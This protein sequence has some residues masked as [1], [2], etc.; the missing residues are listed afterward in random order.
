MFFPVT[1]LVGLLVEPYNLAVV[2]L[3]GALILW[4]LK[5]GRR[6]RRALVI[7]AASLV[8]VFGS[9]PVANLLLYP[10]ETAHARPASLPRSPGAIIVLGGFTDDPRDNPNFY[11]LTEAADR[12]V[13]GVRLAHSFPGARLVISGG[14]SAVIYRFYKEGAVLGSL[15]LDMGLPAR[16]VLVDSESRNTHEN[17]LH[18]KRLLATVKGP[19]VLITSAAH[20]PRAVACFDKVGVEV[21]PWPVD[22]RR[23][24]S[25]PGS[26]LPKPATLERS[27]VALHE[28]AGWLYY[29]LV[30]YV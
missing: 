6:L 14:S 22:Y 1:K 9:G 25:G 19:L 15:A 2:L 10:L 5:R 27:N 11:E 26:W 20:M 13:E 3:L 30:G 16:Q 21:V 24:G 17:A 12:F 29:W 28:Y 7:C 4:R 23:T 18:S 8:L